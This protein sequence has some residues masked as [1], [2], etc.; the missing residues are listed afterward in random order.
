MQSGKSGKYQEQTDDIY[1]SIGLFTVEFEHVILA[2]RQGITFFLHKGGLRNQQLSNNLLAKI[3]AGP[4]K[5][6][7]EAMIPDVVSLSEPD[8]I[9]VNKILKRTQ[10]LIES[11][12]NIIHSTWFVGWA[13]S[14]DT[15]FTNASGQKLTRSKSGVVVKHFDW[16]S[17]DLDKLSK[18]C[19]EVKILLHRLWICIHND[20]KISNN[21]DINE[22]GEVSIPRNSGDIK[23]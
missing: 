23:N 14:K 5:D 1:R 6:I 7:F 8:Q 10:E 3:T 16:K 12:N 15:E 18:E 17:E 19:Y 9:I 13:S 22:A 21:F 11:R 2:M 20:F 4:L